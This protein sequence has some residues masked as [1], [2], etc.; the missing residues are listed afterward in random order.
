MKKGMGRLTSSRS[1]GRKVAG[2]VR[3]PKPT[4]IP[5][6]KAS[7]RRPTSLW[8]M[9]RRAREAV[10]IVRKERKTPEHDGAVPR[11][12]TKELICSGQGSANVI[13][14]VSP[15][16]NRPVWASILS[17]FG[18]IQEL[19]APASTAAAATSSWVPFLTST[20][21]CWLTAEAMVKVNRTLNRAVS[22]SLAL[23][24][25][26]S[27]PAVLMWGRPR[28]LFCSEIEG[29][30]ALVAVSISRADWE[31]GSWAAPHAVRRTMV[32]ANNNKRMDVERAMRPSISGLLPVLLARGSH[33][34]DR[35]VPDQ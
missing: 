23:S 32:V 12:G 7:T 9:A 21:L 19:A 33:Y 13:S 26:I 2:G 24:N 30:D 8:A 25:R 1:R 22:L 6:P 18:G 15:G 16:S 35:F 5:I 27:S 17:S 31:V 11:G 28:L 3:S 29:P 4:S 34:R 20:Q 10:L 14:S